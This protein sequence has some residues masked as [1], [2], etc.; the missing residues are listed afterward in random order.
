MLAIELSASIFCAREMR[1]RCS[2]ASAVTPCVDQA[3]EQVGILRGPEECNQNLA[4]VRESDF[5]HTRHRI[6]PQGLDT[7]RITSLEA[8]ALERR[9]LRRPG[10]SKGLVVKAG[11]PHLRRIQPRPKSQASEVG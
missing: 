8:T 9:W 4:F 6:V 10:P 1:A 7:F 5:V 11:A 2:I 3:P